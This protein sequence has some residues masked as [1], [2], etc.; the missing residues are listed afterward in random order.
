M[1]ETLPTTAIG[2]D[3]QPLRFDISRPDRPGDDL[4]VLMPGYGYSVEMPIFYY[5][6][7]AALEA[8]STVLRVLTDYS[9][10]P[11]FAD[12]DDAIRARW[13][14]HDLT[15]TVDAVRSRR[16][17]GSVTLI[18]KSM[19]TLAIAGLD[20]ATLAGRRSPHVVWLTPLLRDPAVLAAIRAVDRPGMVVIGT[21]DG[22]YDEA[23]L[24]DLATL[25]HLSISVHPGADH[26]LDIPGD[27]DGS[28]ATLRAVIAD[29]RSFAFR[30]M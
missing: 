29:V 26:S 30:T 17:F 4:T 18:G 9:R 15:V 11:G 22:H 3:G 28:I 1:G 12:A 16:A 14:A 27:I 2:F 19:G 24:D 23:L 5:L 6:E 7:Q 13:L 10:S 25:P 8:G 20:P 21:D